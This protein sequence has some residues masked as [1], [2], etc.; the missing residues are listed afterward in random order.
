MIF[1]K[2]ET[3]EC[4]YCGDTM[5]V[6]ELRDPHPEVGVEFIIRYAYCCITCGSMSS[7]WTNIPSIKKGKR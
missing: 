7:V 6:R 4:P 5:K 1:S 2:P 3:D